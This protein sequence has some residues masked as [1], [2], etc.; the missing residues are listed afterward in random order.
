VQFEEFFPRNPINTFLSNL[1]FSLTG[2]VNP[3]EQ[4]N[5]TQE[6]DAT[7]CQIISI[8]HSSNNILVAETTAGGRMAKT[9]KLMEQDHI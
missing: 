8:F 6:I 1:L 5:N 3:V 9:Q 2:K 4:Q 7:A